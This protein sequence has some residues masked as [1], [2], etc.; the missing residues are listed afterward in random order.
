MKL[1]LSAHVSTVSCYWLWY[2]DRAPRG[3]G[4][5]TRNINLFIYLFMVTSKVFLSTGYF[6]ICIHILLDSRLDSVYPLIL[7]YIFFSFLFFS[8]NLQRVHLQQKLCLL[9]LLHFWTSYPLHFKENYFTSSK[10]KLII[11]CFSIPSF[12]QNQYYK[13]LIYRIVL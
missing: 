5:L 10:Q 9:N 7:Y 1:F 8:Y 3:T 2:T 6:I 11:N 12:L 13:Y 4:A